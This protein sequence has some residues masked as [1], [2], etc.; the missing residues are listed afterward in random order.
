MAMRWIAN[1][2]LTGTSGVFSNVLIFSL[3]NLP[4]LRAVVL[5][6]NSRYTVLEEGGN[7]EDGS[8]WLYLGIA[9]TLVV[10]GGVFAGL[11]IA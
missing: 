9:L 11:T 4:L 6:L 10:L 7:P 3:M 8:L 1:N 5:P 2:F